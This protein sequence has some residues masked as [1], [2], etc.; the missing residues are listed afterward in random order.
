MYR[1]FRKAHR[2]NHGTTMIETTISVVIMTPIVLW[3]FEI[4]M[5]GYATAVMQYAARAG[6]QYATTHGT[7]AP[8][9]SGPGGKVHGSCPDA[10]GGSITQLVVQVAK[11]SGQTLE[12]SRVVS[13]WTNGTN[14]PG[15]PIT[16]NINTPYTPM[17]RLPF[18]PPRI[19]GTATGQVVY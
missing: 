10:S 15:D 17:I 16:V 18:V 8:N 6:V 12:S 13:N 2:D 5:F 19:N 7:D 3:V 9:C 14:N 1:M 4:C 11:S